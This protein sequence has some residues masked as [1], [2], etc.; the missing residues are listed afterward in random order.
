VVARVLIANRGE[1][2]RRIARTCHRLGVETVAVYSDADRDA[3]HVRDADHAVRIGP[4]DARASY[5]DADRLLRVVRET[6]CDAVH[7]GYGF[8][9]ENA[10]F[11]RACLD[12]GV[13]FIGPSPEVIE[14]MGDKAAAKRRLAAAGVPVVPGENRDDLDDDQLITA[15]TDVGFPLL[16]KAV[17][18]GGG[19]GMRTV[20]EADGLPA[21]LA[22]ARR[23]ATAAFGDGRVILERLVTRPRH[24]EIQVFGDRHGTVVHLLERECSIQR[25]HQKLVE[26]APS[27]ALGPEL[28]ARMGAAAVTAAAE[29]GY[30]G[31]GTVEFLL[32]G[33]TLHDPEPAFYFLEM[34]TR[35][36][37]EHPVT[38]AITG[39]DL[40]ELQLRV[41]DGL[42]LGFDQDDVRA[43]G[44][45]I[46]VRLY[47]EDPV[48]HLPQTGPVLALE[49]PSDPDVRFDSGIEVG[50]EVGR[51]YD[52]MLAKLIVHGRDREAACNRLSE[53]LHDTS[54]R[55]ITTNLALL[56]AIAHAPAFRAGELTT[57]FLDDHLAGWTPP[58]PDDTT[59]LT[60]LAA[61]V[62][63]HDDHR[64][65]G[66][67][68]VGSPW[69]R[70][71][72]LRPTGGGGWSVTLAASPEGTVRTAS[73]RST[74]TGPVA[75]LGDDA[76]EQPLPA[77]TRADVDGDARSDHT[78]W[79][80]GPSGTHRL[81]VK[82]PTRWAD[83]S[84]PTGRAA[85]TAPMPGAVLAVAVAPGDH[86]ASG[87]T[88]VV[89]EAMKME[90]P[91]VAP[92][93]GTVLAVQVAAGQT[94]D[95]GTELLTFE[96]DL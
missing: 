41:A 12:A 6:G 19:K 86:V 18:G 9:A 85:F 93:D 60:A 26:E 49:V 91:I 58:P 50:S 81:E 22:S 3:P 66:M 61:L 90:H 79:V 84:A 20:H 13:T 34:N 76:D 1:I 67:E 52:P 75:T 7:P 44:H 23:E 70:L 95:A 89:V 82:P 92:T 17:A 80:H 30:E 56:A 71:G 77:A 63:R 25:R 64:D 37:V 11:A 32:D 31:A 45:A 51:H 39:L 55:G 15:A 42:P 46:E 2:A 40:V 62:T 27:P 33:T 43:E 38:E 10:A 24:V 36:Q 87:T 14:L 94:V 5:L 96:P 73:V 47:A 21:A 54:V 88:M 53:V 48:T 72:P 78:V 4:A 65:A 59:V 35:L 16:V 57:S 83:A 68:G 74:A 69:A 8:L 29:V 28:R